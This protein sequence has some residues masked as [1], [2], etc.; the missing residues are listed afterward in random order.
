M[1][2]N[3]HPISKEWNLIIQSLK[4]KDTH[5]C[6]GSHHGAMECPLVKNEHLLS[7]K[8]TYIWLSLSPSLFLNIEFKVRPGNNSNVGPNWITDIVFY[9]Q[10]YHCKGKRAVL[11]SMSWV[12]TKDKIIGKWKDFILCQVKIL[13]FFY[14][15]LYLRV[16]IWWRG[17]GKI[18]IIYLLH[19]LDYLG[20]D[21]P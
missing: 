16:P 19:F 13:Y 18:R 11:F 3:I 7:S 21:G 4:R 1:S 15:S 9:R 14:E 5:L 8:D 20:P 12:E 10:L 6:S 2:N 17:Y